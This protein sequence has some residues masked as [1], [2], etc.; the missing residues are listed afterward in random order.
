MEISKKYKL[1]PY[2][3]KAVEW[4]SS[5]ESGIIYAD[6]GL[7]KS[8][9]SLSFLTKQKGPNLIIC[10]KT[11]ITE[12]ISQIEK[13]CKVLPKYFVYHSDFNR[14]LDVNL[15]DYDIVFTTYGKV[16]S[17]NKIIRKKKVIKKRSEKFFYKLSENSHWNIRDYKPIT[18]KTK[19]LYG[20]LWNSIICDECQTVCN[21]ATFKYKAVYS[22]PSKKIYGLSGTP[23]KN[24]QSELIG[25]AKLMRIEDFKTPFEWGS[26]TLTKDHKE[27]FDKFHMITYGTAGVYIPSR[28]NIIYEL[29]FSKNTMDIINSYIKVTD[30]LSFE[31]GSKK[32]TSMLTLFTRF[33]QIAID[34]YILL[35]SETGLKQY[36][37]I[38][39]GKNLP[40]FGSEKYYKLLEILNKIKYENDKFIIFSTFSSYLECL[41]K[42]ITIRPTFFIKAKFS[43]KQRKKLIDE[44]RKT[45]NGILIMN[46]EIGAEG[47]NLIE[48]KHIVLLDSWFNNAKESQAIAR[49]HRIGQTNEITIHRLIYKSSIE[50]IMYRKCRDKQ[51]LYY[52]IR[53]SEIKKNESSL[54]SA[55]NISKMIRAM[56][57]EIAE[58][59][60]VNFDDEDK[61]IMI[62]I[63]LVL[64]RKFK[65]VYPKG[66]AYK[67]IELLFDIPIFVIKKIY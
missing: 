61:Y 25:L 47:L 29:N 11:L 54:L 13:H 14:K 45:D 4:L 5:H 49:A 23:I 46:Y 16:I 36:N 37:E 31:W 7:G 19:D 20:V 48:A 56:K 44:W 64:K 6:M 38:C 17:D 59:Q 67:V 33:R 66:I 24:N 51:N 50:I 65:N 32:Y 12:W 63:T 26:E 34:P 40:I 35:L 3:L 41:D 27:V 22:L 60:L 2:Q 42:K 62:Y 58:E 53:D 15:K 28:N 21:W 30:G 8:L 10:S 1:Y 9:I 55:K 52:K 39:K 43:T 57:G 18:Y